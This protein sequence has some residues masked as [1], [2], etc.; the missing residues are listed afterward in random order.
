[1]AE[2]LT[3]PIS[4]TSPDIFLREIDLDH[5]GNVEEN[6]EAVE[7]LVRLNTVPTDAWQQEFMVAY[8]RTPYILK[9]PV[10]LVGDTI[11][12]VYLP[13]YAGELQGYID[14]LALIVARSNTETHRSEEL[15]TSNAQERQKAAFRES[16]KQLRLHRK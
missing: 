10:R 11:H 7:F 2:T 8:E 5:L 3:E 6:R 9:P 12:I 13:R 14:F 1:M 4:E 16:L 15:H